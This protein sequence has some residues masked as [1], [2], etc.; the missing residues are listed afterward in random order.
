MKTRV[1][2]PQL[3]RIYDADKAV[4]PHSNAIKA[5]G[6]EEL[7]IALAVAYFRLTGWTSRALET[8]CIIDGGGNHLDAWIETHK[9]GASVYYQ[10]EVKAWS[11]HG[12]NGG[13]PLPVDEVGGKVSEF[14]KLTF[15]RYWKADSG[16]FRYASLDKVLRKAKTLHGGTVRA[17][18]CLWAPMHPEGKDEP[19]FAVNVVAESSPFEQI[20]FFS[21]SSFLRWYRKEFE[22]DYIDLDLPDTN[23]RMDYLQQIYSPTSGTFRAPL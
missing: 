3:L 20:W 17:L 19:L 10:T 18:A 7:G 6:G 11:F 9:D 5:V 1:N 2:I 12:Y 8:S 4:R 23:A 15:E 13:P 21:A 14:K 16:Q 22:V